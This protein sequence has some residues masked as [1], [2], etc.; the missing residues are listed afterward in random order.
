MRRCAG[1]EVVQEGD[2]VVRVLQNGG[3]VQSVMAPSGVR[4][5]RCAAVLPSLVLL[6]AIALAAHNNLPDP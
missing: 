6:L 2:Q 3:L 5:R 1:L 4:R